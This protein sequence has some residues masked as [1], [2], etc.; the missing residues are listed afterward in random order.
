MAVLVVVALRLWS[1]LVVLGASLVSLAGAFAFFLITA[2]ADTCGSST[3]ADVV[4]WI[5]GI[6]LAL[7]V[8]AWG[9]RRGA[10][11]Y[12]AIP[13]GWVAAALWFVLVAHV[14]HGGTGGCFE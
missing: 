4:S 5:G 2:S 9:V 8:G 13:A 3:S 7:P 6:V 1:P 10:R 14:V 12:V 11:V